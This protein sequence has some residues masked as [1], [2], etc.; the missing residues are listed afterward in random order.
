MALRPRSDRSLVERIVLRAAP[1]F[2]PLSE[3]GETFE[4]LQATASVIWTL[5]R[6]WRLE[7]TA[8]AGLVLRSDEPASV[9]SLET[10]ATWR[11]GALEFSAGLRGVWQRDI[12][13]AS[14]PDHKASVPI[15]EL[16]AFLAVSFAGVERL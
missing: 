4:Q 11:P 3:S 9:A 10:R 15:K 2:D 16:G 12:R 13:V 6:F 14:T 7:G 8:A 5:S 1:Y